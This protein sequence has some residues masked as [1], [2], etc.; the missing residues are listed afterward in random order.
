MIS[1]IVPAYNAKNTIKRAVDSI[2]NQVKSGLDY[3]IIIVDDGS[4]DNLR[5]EIAK[6]PTECLEKITYTRKPNGGLSDARNYGVKKAKG[7]YIIFVDSDDYVDTR[8]LKDIKVCI[9][10]NVD[11]IKWNPI[12]IYEDG[13]K[14]RKKYYDCEL[15]LLSGEEGFN[16]LFGEDP[17]MSCTW[18]YC[19]KKEYVPIFPVGMYHEDF[20]TTTLMMLQVKTMAIMNKFEYYYVQTNDSITRG[21]DSKKQLKR[22]Q[23]LVKHCDNII[24]ESAKMS[25]NKK[26]KENVR[27][28]CANVLL[29][30]LNEENISD[31]NRKYLTK[32]IKKR[33][34]YKDIKAR[35]PKQFIKKIYLFVKYN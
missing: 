17:L 32:E 18:N 11:L 30:C 4:T 27:I 33:K 5:S 16:A 1:F 29:S 34:I 24:K 7:D 35:N 8:L 23:D 20:A 14:E 13:M 28:Y 25:I 26:T 3:E 2:L 22:F 15:D 10:N 31:S 21:N 12:Y 19:I 9:K 6:Y